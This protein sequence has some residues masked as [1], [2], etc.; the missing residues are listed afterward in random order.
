VRVARVF[1][2]LRLLGRERSLIKIHRNQSSFAALWAL[3]YRAGT[4]SVHPRVG[5]LVFFEV[6]PFLGVGVILQIRA[7]AQLQ[8]A[9]PLF[10]GYINGNICSSLEVGKILLFS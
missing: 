10:N 1:A 7:S 9:S 3:F 6:F 8:H 5:D 2:S 4:P